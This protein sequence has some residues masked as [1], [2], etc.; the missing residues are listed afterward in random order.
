MELKPMNHDKNSIERYIA[1]QLWESQNVSELVM[2]H[3]KFIVFAD[4]A[5]LNAFVIK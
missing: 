4:T 2:L 3:V 1:P 5:N